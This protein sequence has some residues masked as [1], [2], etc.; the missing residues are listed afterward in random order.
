MNRPR[1]TIVALCWMAACTSS[2]DSV[3]GRWQRVDQPTEWMQF[4]E[5]GRFTA[6]SFMDT[7]LVRG[8]YRQQGTEVVGTSTFGFQQT[9][10]LQDSLLVMQD[11]TKYRRVRPARE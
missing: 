3:V 7:M 2:P 8:A 11:G 6:R 5:D 9:L 10:E 4:E 1:I